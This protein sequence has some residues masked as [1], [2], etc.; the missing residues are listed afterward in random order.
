[1]HVLFWIGSGIRSY[2]HNLII[3][4]RVKIQKGYIINF[5]NEGLDDTPSPYIFHVR[6]CRYILCKLGECST[7]K[8]Y[9]R[10]R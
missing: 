7:S 10:K 6:A 1:M 2:I 4:Y 3:I 9:L 5:I 8:Y